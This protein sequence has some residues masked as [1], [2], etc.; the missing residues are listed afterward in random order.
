MVQNKTQVEAYL[1]CQFDANYATA[2]KNCVSNA[3][4]FETKSYTNLSCSDIGG[5]DSYRLSEC[6]DS[7]GLACKLNSNG[8]RFCS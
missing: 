7:L 3:K 5:D 8:A 2:N 4:S 6:D 1:S